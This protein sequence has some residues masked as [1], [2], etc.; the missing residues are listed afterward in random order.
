[1]VTLKRGSSNDWVIDNFGAIKSCQYAKDY[2]RCNSQSCETIKQLDAST[3][4]P[5]PLFTQTVADNNGPASEKC[6]VR[7]CEARKRRKTIVSE[8]P[9]SIGA[10]TSI[11][12]PLKLN[13]TVTQGLFQFAHQRIFPGSQQAR[14]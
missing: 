12:A 13:K 9:V 5:I 10:S 4:A 1:M 2:S 8:P 11:G 3:S 6:E 7:D 14:D